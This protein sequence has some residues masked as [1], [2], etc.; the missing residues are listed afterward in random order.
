MYQKVFYPGSSIPKFDLETLSKVKGIPDEYTDL[1]TSRQA[2][3]ERQNPP[4]QEKGKSSVTPI[5]R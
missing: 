5:E 1:L 4:Q 2:A 3:K